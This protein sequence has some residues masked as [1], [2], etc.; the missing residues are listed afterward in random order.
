MD[1]QR[2]SGLCAVWAL[3][4]AVGCGK[5]SPRP[6]AA[7]PL[8]PEAG[9]AVGAADGQAAAPTLAE[10]RKTLTT[11]D[12]SS[13][14]VLTIDQIAT[15]GSAAKEA[16]DDLLKMT[17]DPE[18]R[19]R[20]HAARAIGNVGED[21][22]PAVPKLVSLLKDEDPI[23]AAQ[24]AAA[25]RLIRA[26]DERTEL[27]PQDAAL[28]AAAI[29]PLMAATVHPDPRVRRAAAG[30][31]GL[32]EAR[33][34]ALASLLAKTLADSDPSVILPA[35]HTLADMDGAAVPVLIETLKDPKSR[36][37]A[38][39]ALAE[40]G[41]EA[42]PAV[43]GLTAV[44]TTGEPEERMQA[45]LALAA[46]GPA[47]AA[48]TPMIIDAARSGDGSLRFA[49]VFALGKLRAM[50]ADALLTEIENGSDP[51]LAEIAAWA[52]ARIHPE[53]ARLRQAA[54][55]K[56]RGGLASEFPK[57]RAASASGLSDL[58]ELLEPELR[59]QLAEA[60]VGLLADPEPAVGK[61]AGA[62]LVRLGG[63]A[64]DALKA[65]VAKPQVRLPIL[66]ILAAIGPA[67]KAAMPEVTAALS[68]DDAFVRGEAAVALGAIG[69]E[70]A[71]A[72]A[73]LEAI[74]ADEGEEP[75]TRYSAAYALGR[76]G[77]AAAP[78]MKTIRGLSSSAD[79]LMATVAVWAA[80]KIEPG[81]AQ[82]FE[83][84]MPRLRKALRADSDL[85]RLEAAVALGEIGPDAQAA[86]PI[87]ELVEEDDP[88]RAVRAAAAAA[89][90]KIRGG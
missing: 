5:P 12:D 65:S 79:E 10:L 29:E 20:W 56:L 61:Q 81:N 43:A 31:V 54:I 49:A 36:Y 74:L 37:W 71:P 57:V 44:A 35:L 26:D 33:P 58:A 2:L 39:V 89:L 88:V 45:M 24:A 83:A 60:F 25:I 70:A 14:R 67:G 86:V 41:P 34:E 62:A 53:D 4:L 76:I 72:V 55:E 85:A 21:A 27:P 6:V 30:A 75:G 15:L 18:S 84:A 68:D 51:F 9:A 48:A 32:L 69:T 17:A 16:I 42:S 46:I 73:S 50:E 59:R 28:Y 1:R 11:T 23:T 22:L 3:C 8:Q 87:L 90:A 40:I 52:H 78:A 82:L 77:P 7:K 66:E 80:L 13:I 38:A 47:A 64:V 63:D 19:V